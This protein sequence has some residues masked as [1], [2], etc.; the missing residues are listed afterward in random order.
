MN[1]PK[2][3]R[4]RAAR[5]AQDAAAK[6]AAAKDAAAQVVPATPAVLAADS[7]ELEPEPELARA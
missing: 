3:T 2:K 4:A 6:D 7:A 5:A 1:A